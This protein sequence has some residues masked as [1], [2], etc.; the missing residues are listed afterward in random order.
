[1][2]STIR[3][4]D[5]FRNP[6][7][8]A[9]TDKPF[10]VCVQHDF[11]ADLNT[12]VVVSLAARRFGSGA[13]RLHPEIAVNSIIHFLD[14]TDILT[15]SVRTLGSPIANLSGQRDRIVAALDLVFTGI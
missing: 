4:L 11:L 3:H 10:V 1:M 14:P 5:V 12:R 6:V 13:D 7:R 9:R 2:P 15:F 8:A